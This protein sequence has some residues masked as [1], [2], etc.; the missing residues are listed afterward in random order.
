MKIAIIAP[1]LLPNWGGVG[2]YSIELTKYLSMNDDIELHVVTLIRSV[3]NITYTKSEI[4]NY[5]NRKISLHILG[6]A[7]ETF[8]YNIRFQHRV[9]KELPGIIKHH[10]IDLVHSQHAHMPDILL[11]LRKIGISSATTVHSTIKSQYQGI[12]ATN[13]SWSEMDN[14]EKYQLMLYPVLSIAEKFYLMKCDNLICVSR[15]TLNHLKTDCRLSN[16]NATV[17]HNG[18]DPNRFSP[19]KSSDSNILNSIQDPIVLYASRLTAARGAHVLAQAIPKILQENREVHFV[20]AGAGDTKPIFNILRKNGVPR[21]KHTI[22]GYVDYKDLPSLY[23]R[24]YVYVMPTSWEN[25]PFKMLEA[26]SSGTPVITTNVGGISEVIEDSYNGLFTSRSPIA[27][28]EK[29]IQLL[30]D[31]KFAKKLGRNARNTILQNFTWAKTVEKTKKYY[32]SIL[33]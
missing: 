6:N 7:T 24:A 21:E 18:V 2:T 26:M 22:L 15:W 13:Q 11:K 29:A 16:I 20:F 14:S 12:K 32:E 10:K 17:I 33:S 27:I 3:G 23:A 5:F 25:L 28:A 30:D 4:L 8:L 9:F 19:D 31:E 1:E